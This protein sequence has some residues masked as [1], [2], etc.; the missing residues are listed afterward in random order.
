MQTN[1]YVF[2][3]PDELKS[4]PGHLTAI[5]QHP[6]KSAKVLLDGLSVHC[7]CNCTVLLD[8]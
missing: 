6:T 7:L 2:S 8:V 1:C 4:N 3:A 5:V